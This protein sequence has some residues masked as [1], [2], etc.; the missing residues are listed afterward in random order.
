MNSIEFRIQ[1]NEST[2]Y[3]RVGG[4][5][6]SKQPCITCHGHGIQIVTRQIGPNMMQRMQKICAD[7]SGEGKINYIDIFM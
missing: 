4:R 1:L 2:I 6:G 5:E 7:C 3:C